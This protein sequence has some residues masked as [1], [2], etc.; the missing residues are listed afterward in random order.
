M[1]SEATTRLLVLKF[2]QLDIRQLFLP[3]ESHLCY[4]RSTCTMKRSLVKDVFFSFY[5]V[6]D[7]IF[8]SLF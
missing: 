1:Q 7:V 2:G 3:D 4:D 6:K 5:T 8:S